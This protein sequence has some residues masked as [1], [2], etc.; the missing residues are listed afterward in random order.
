[1]PRALGVLG[2]VLLLGGLGH[3]IGI[4]HLYLTKGCPETNRLMFDLWIAQAQFIGGGLYV[5]ASRAIGT[6]TAWRPLAFFAALTIVGFTVSVIPVLF[7]RGA[8]FFRIP[9]VI[10]LLA[11]IAILAHLVKTR[12]E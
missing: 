4:T 2:V 1:M 11:S 8:V 6:G 5:A 10:Y 3:S 7:S 9:P 12:G